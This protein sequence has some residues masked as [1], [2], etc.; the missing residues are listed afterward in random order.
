M[1]VAGDIGVGGGGNSEVPITDGETGWFS[2]P[3]DFSEGSWTR[4]TGGLE[5]PAPGF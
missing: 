5:G 1:G 2:Y 4:G 3:G